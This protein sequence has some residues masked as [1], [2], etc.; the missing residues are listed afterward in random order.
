M[1]RG[2]NWR[3]TLTEYAAISG[4]LAGLCVAFIALIL[5][6][7]I[8]NT[9]IYQQLTFG[10]LAV[11]FFGIATSLFISASEFFLHSK[12]FDVFDTTQEYRNWVQS[13][14]PDK[15]WD[16]IWKESTMMMRVNDRYGRWCYNVALFM[17]F[18]GL[19]FAVGPYNLVVAIAVSSMGIAL[20]IWQFRKE[21]ELHRF[22]KMIVLATASIL[23]AY[24]GF[25]LFDFFYDSVLCIYNVRWKIFITETVQIDFFGAVLPTI[26]SILFVFTLAHFR[27]FS[28]KY[29]LLNSPLPVA[30]ALSV[31]S[32][33]PAAIVSY[34][35]ILAL[36]VSLLVVF[37]AFYDKGWVKFLKLR[38]FDKLVISK[39]TYVNAL[40]IAFSY[41]S[42]STLIVDLLFL[43]FA[44][45]AY[46]G[47]M[48]LID[49]I[50]LSGLVTPVSMTLATL[51]FMTACE[52]RIQQV[53]GLGS[54]N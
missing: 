21:L 46:I 14:F 28:I 6:W 27:K 49:G 43:P 4:V 36:L 47:G 13:G 44:T 51:F 45:T 52:L 5:A 2:Y 18:L 32:L 48:G 15:N 16:E 31:T 40:L 34:Y 8:A 26:L 17:L 54:S 22:R 20:Q 37:V 11:L 10:N 53:K 30:F 38:E 7:S 9:E 50:M 42:L 1:S 3:N 25:R 35:K 41:A 29:Y 12:D 19:F 33:T 24:F 39:K 23:L